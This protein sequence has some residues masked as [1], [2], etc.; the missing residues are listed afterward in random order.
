M[1]R[2]I[3]KIFLL[4]AGM[5]FVCTCLLMGAHTYYS[6]HYFNAIHDFHNPVAEIMPNQKPDTSILIVSDSGS[7]NLILRRVLQDALDKNKY[8]F[9]MH[10]GDFTKNASITGTYWLLNDIKPVLGKTPLYMI[11]GNH[12][13]TR[14]IG[15]TKKHFTDKSF[16]ETVMGPRYYWFAFGDTL[17][18]TLD[19]SDTGLDDAQLAW[20]DTTLKKIR[21]GFKNCIVFG[22]VPPANSRPDFFEDHIMQPDTVKKFEQIVK[23]HKINAMFFGHVHFFSQSKFAGID[24]YT[25]PSSGQAIRD[26]NIRQ[27]GYINVNINK[28]GDVSVEPKF[29]DYRGPKKSAFSEW[30]ARDVLSVK[31]KMMVS[32]GLCLSIIFLIV[33]LV[34][35]KRK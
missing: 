26:P 6:D 19:S 11:P 12:D 17:F 31:V 29:I 5:F 15:L 9:V 2:T 1:K 22:H 20:F 27:Y 33:G 8:D 28:K 13:I 30:F 14:R 10:L 7:H 4:L 24:F 35:R 16:Y 21:P 3:S 34:L 25:L 23:K 18:I 32:A